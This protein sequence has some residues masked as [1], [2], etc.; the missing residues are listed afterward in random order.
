MKKQ[1]SETIGYID[2]LNSILGAK[3]EFKAALDES[4]LDKSGLELIKRICGDIIGGYD[5]LSRDEKELLEYDYN[6]KEIH[7][8][9]KKLAYT[10]G[11]VPKERIKDAF[12]IIEDRLN[13]LKLR[14]VRSGNIGKIDSELMLS[15]AKLSKEAYDKKFRKHFSKSQKEYIDKFCRDHGARGFPDYLIEMMQNIA[16]SQDK[17]D[18]LICNLRG[19]L[20]YTLIFEL[21]GFPREKLHYISCGKNSGRLEDSKSGLKFR[22]FDGMLKRMSGK[23]VLIVDN[24]ALTGDTL[25]SVAE[26][27][28]NAGA[29]RISVFLDHACG[30]DERFIRELSQ[31]IDEAYVCM[32]KRSATKYYGFWHRLKNKLLGK[33]DFKKEKTHLLEKIKDHQNKTI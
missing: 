9:F 25:K 23:R 10:N 26:I 31:Y 20:T 22:D 14:Y 27:L 2:R 13:N 11:K 18:Y 21:M 3:D 17:Y 33:I 6:L 30:K 24:M 12:D 1:I 5:C 4:H 15:L 16:N 32:S 8:Y 28:K 7:F 29:S 19:G